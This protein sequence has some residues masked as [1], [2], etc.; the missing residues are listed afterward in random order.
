ME[1]ISN[2]N[3]IKKELQAEQNILKAD[4]EY[5]LNREK[6]LVSE[7]QILLDKLLKLKAVLSEAK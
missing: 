5:L 4:Y 3:R 1:N 2:N 7:K 6:K